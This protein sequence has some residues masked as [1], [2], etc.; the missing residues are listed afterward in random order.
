MGSRRLSLHLI[1]RVRLAR[2]GMSSTFASTES[3]IQRHTAGNNVWLR[4]AGADERAELMAHVPHGV[5][6]EGLGSEEAVGRAMLVEIEAAARTKSGDL[7][8]VILGGRGA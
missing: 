3:S 5:T 2:A 4:R 8:I 7:T 1:G 6:F